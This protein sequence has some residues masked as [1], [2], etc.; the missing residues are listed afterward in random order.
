MKKIQNLSFDEERAFYGKKNLDL[1]NCKNQGKA[2]GESAFKEC[3]NIKATQCLFDLRYP[4][5]HTKKIGLQNC[6]LSYSCRAPLW[7]SQN[8][9]IL[10]SK[11]FAVKAVR[12]CSNV[13]FDG[14]D[15]RSP[16][17]I[18]FSDKITVK[19]SKMQGEYFMF[20]SS[21]GVFENLDFQGKYSFQYTKNL[22]L[23]NCVLFT[24]DA[25]WHSKNVVVKNSVVTG[26][27]LGWY[28]KNLTLENCE[29][30]GTQ[31]FCYCENLTLKNCKMIDCDL[32]FEKSSVKATITTK[33]DSIKNPKS[34]KITLPEV[35]EIILDD[36]GA[37][38]KIEVLR[39]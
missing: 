36:K 29:I 32:A 26:E 14:C 27:Y 30:R 23:N 13:Y 18:W 17:C 2:D 5:W 1:H 22:T 25:F 8:I 4:L 16:E 35:G 38:G 11:V 20:K 37:K 34:G 33:V 3:E 9:N 15:I 31:P 12:E 28:S 6:E 7:Y 24:K 39:K 21:N 10:Q 19:N